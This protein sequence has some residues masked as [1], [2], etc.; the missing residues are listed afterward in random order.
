MKVITFLGTRPEIIK[1]SL[2]IQKLDAFDGI[3]HILVHT[4]QNWD[5]KLKDVFFK[6]LGVREPDYYLDVKADTLGKQIANIIERS[7][8]VLIKERPDVY[9]VLG[10]TN[11]ALSAIVAARMGIPVLHMEAGNRSFDSRVPE[12]LNRKMIDHISTWLFPYRSQ[13]RENLIREG[14]N[15]AKIFISGDPYIEVL[16]HHMEKINQNDVV[17]RLDLQP[18]EYFLATTHREENVD[19]PTSLRNIAEGMMQV[20]NK[21]KKKI[22]WSLHPRTPKKLE[23]LNIQLPANIEIVEPLGF[24]DFVALEKDAIC[25]ISDSGTAL[26]EGT[27]LRVPSVVIREAIERPEV[28]E[29]GA[30]VIS[31]TR[32]SEDIL[33]AVDAALQSTKKWLSPYDHEG[34]VSDKMVNFIVSHKQKVY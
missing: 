15:P 3:D 5:P 8:E 14:I 10:D 29:V 23:A 24:L 1:M 30:T 28:L 12:E 9:L 17:A 7:E 33:R 27:V 18:K 34:S 2:V 26:Q 32:K 25:I 22:I 11:S 20:A 16:Q 19:D 31:G 6:E 21:Y 4:G 13:P